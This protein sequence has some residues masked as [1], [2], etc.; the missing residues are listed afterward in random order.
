MNAIEMMDPR[1]DT[2][3]SLD[4]ER[5]PFDIH[6]RLSA[7]QTIYVMDR[8]I[9]LEMAWIEGHQIPQTVFTCIYLHHL[10][11]LNEI[12][13]PTI[14]SDVE[15]IVF[16]ALKSYLLATAKCCHYVYMEMLNRNV[17]EVK[18]KK[19]KRDDY[20]TLNSKRISQALFM[21]SL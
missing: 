5:Q 7:K 17:F 9:T 18:T 13:M 16:G 2:G 8:L 20:L 14:E 19:H 10:R 1:M 6:R 4:E 11:E 12:P 3:M 15:E 21:D